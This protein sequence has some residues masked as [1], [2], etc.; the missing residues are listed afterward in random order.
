MKKIINNFLKTFVIVLMISIAYSLGAQ[1][2]STPPGGATG[3]GN[4]SSNSQGGRVPI[5]SGLLIL[6][7]L[8]A[9][10]GGKKIYDL[11]KEKLEE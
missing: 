6:I 10:Y 3:D 9:A 11:R 7:G 1:P 8:G 5:G 2:P 4:D